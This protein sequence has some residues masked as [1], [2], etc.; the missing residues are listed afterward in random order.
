MKQIQRIV[1]N[2][3][4]KWRIP[5]EARTLQPTIG[6]VLEDE[7]APE[8]QESM[9]PIGPQDEPTK[10]ENLSSWQT[11]PSTLLA[12]SPEEEECDSP[13]EDKFDNPLIAYLRGKSTLEIFNEEL[14]PGDQIIAYMQGEPVI[15]VFDP[16]LTPD[17]SSFSEPEYSYGR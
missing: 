11:K 9:E 7:P 1:A 17:L 6:E 10:Q 5:G 14:E 12:L 8:T 4:E 16:L 3:R 13:D 15:R 2:A